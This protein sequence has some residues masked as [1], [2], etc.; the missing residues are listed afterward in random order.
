MH[1]ASLPAAMRPTA[2][3]RPWRCRII[4]IFW[5]FSGIRSICGR[6]ILCPPIYLK[7]LWRP[8]GDS[9]KSGQQERPAAEKQLQKNSCR[10]TAA[11]KR[12]QKNGCRKT[13]AERPYMIHAANICLNHTGP[14]HL[15]PVLISCPYLLSLSAYCLLSINSP[16]I[17]AISWAVMGLSMAVMM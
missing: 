10:K 9:W 13:A 4:P 12:L 8:A 1:P 15:S 2:S 6:Q 16:A 5:P 11:E 17:W 14:S 3:S 7:A